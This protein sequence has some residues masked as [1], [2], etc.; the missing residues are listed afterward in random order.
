MFTNLTCKLSKCVCEFRTECS[1]RILSLSVCVCLPKLNTCM[2]IYTQL[3]KSGS[4][5]LIDGPKD[6][7]SIIVHTKDQ[8]GPR[9]IILRGLMVEPW[10]NHIFRSPRRIRCILRGYPS[11]RTSFKCCPSQTRRIVDLVNLQTTKDIVYIQTEYR[12][13][14][15]TSAPTNSPLA[16]ALS[17][18]SMVVDSS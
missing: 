2:G 7:L 11:I 14:T 1:Q 9:R 12:Q 8:H 4:K 15:D 10:S 18:S 17:L 5:D 3:M 16:V 6:H 13:S